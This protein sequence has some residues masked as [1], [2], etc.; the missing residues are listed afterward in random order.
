MIKARITDNILLE[1]LLSIPDDKREIFLLSNGHFRLSAVSTTHMVNEARYNHNAGLLESYILSEGYTAGALL[2]SEVKGNDRI[3]L[4][5]ECG[6]S[7]KGMSIEA[8]ASGAVRG[9][10]FNNPIPLK[11]PLKSLDTNELFGPGFLSITKILEGAKTPFT[12]QIMMEY[13]NLSKDLALYYTQSAE[14]PS[15]FDLAT[16]YDREGRITGAGGLF[17]QALPECSD[18][19]KEDVSKIFENL[20]KLGKFLSDKGDIRDYVFSAFSSL[21]PEHLAHSPIGFSCPCSRSA[22]ERYLLSMPEKE[23]KEILSGEF[24]LEAECFNCGTKYSFSREELE[25]LFKTK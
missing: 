14:T 8:W 15:A 17:V 5:I 7:I 11:E 18:T 24:P 3:Q 16:D 21:N 22:M 10:I 1:H 12:G 25:K 2:S 4:S 9:Y 13:G 23:K 19:E 20:P 6:G